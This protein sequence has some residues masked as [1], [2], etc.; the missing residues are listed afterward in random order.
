MRRGRGCKRERMESR[1]RG[2]EETERVEERERKTEW[3]EKGEDG[4]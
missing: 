4:G 1:G 2:C 3:K